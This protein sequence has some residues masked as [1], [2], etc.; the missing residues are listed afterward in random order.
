MT[1]ELEKYEQTIRRKHSFAWTPKYEEEFQTNLSRT[2]VSAIAIKTFERLEWDIVYQGE[3]SIEAKRKD[4]W[5][6][7]TEKITVSYNYGKV[8]VKS[9]SLN[10]SFWGLGVEFSSGE[11]FY[12]HFCGN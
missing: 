3:E 4:R 8:K 1:E 7:W 6:R 2:L 10:G 9:V 5:N 11:A 12:K